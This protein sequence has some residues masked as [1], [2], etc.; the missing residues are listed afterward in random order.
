MMPQL[1]T[2]LEALIAK[3]TYRYF[4]ELASN[5]LDHDGAPPELPDYRYCC[6]RVCLRGN[7]KIFDCCCWLVAG[8]RNG[9]PLNAMRL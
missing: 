2:V 4:C 7:N 6:A 9:F 8:L 3:P 5:K 1:L